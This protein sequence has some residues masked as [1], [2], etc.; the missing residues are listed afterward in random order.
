MTIDRVISL[1]STAGVEPVVVQQNDKESRTVRFFVYESS[2][3]PLDVQGKTAR[4]FFRKNGA[5]SQA[6]EAAVAADG[7][8]SLTV[9][10]EVTVYPGNGE[11][12]LAL[13]YGSSILHSFTIPF[14]VKGSLSFMGETESPEDDPM[15]IAWDTLP[16]K[17]DTFPPSAHTHTPAQAGALPANGTAADAA[18]LGGKLPKYY[19]RPRNLLD[20]SRF[21][22]PVNQRGQASYTGTGYGLDRWRTNFSGDTVEVLAGGVKNTVAS[23]T[24]GWH[25][26]QIID[27]GA[28]LVGK[29]I[30]AACN[31]AAITGALYLLISCRNSNDTEI[32]HVS[33]KI[34]AGLNVTSLTVPSG[35]VYI[36]VGVYA[37]ATSVAVG[38]SVTL[39]WVA[40]YEGE[41]TAETLPSYVPKGYAAEL[42]ACQRDYHI[43][44][45]QAARPAHGLDCVPHMRL[46]NPTQGTIVIGGV[47]YYYNAADL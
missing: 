45:T 25:L 47:T 33:Q 8:I 2:G 7:W 19:N 46:N 30:T 43:Y 1:S 24:G 27:N 21:V 17:P 13:V 38:D 29:S 14:S 5:T 16:G 41:Y 34:A 23:T 9:P 3:V 20:N 26:H 4:I 35:T 15:R 12:Q 40:L 22:K 31:A 44:A 37:Y 28:E 39:E 11:M 10:E 6:Y 36:R 18:K 42:L 32:E